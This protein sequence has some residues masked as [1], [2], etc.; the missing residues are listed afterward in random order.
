[1]SPGPWLSCGESRCEFRF[2]N[3]VRVAILTNVAHASEVEMYL[4][5]EDG[6]PYGDQVVWPLPAGLPMMR[7]LVQAQAAEGL[8]AAFACWKKEQPCS[9]L[10]RS[11]L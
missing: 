7:A 5:G 3:G 6:E 11:A 9:T 2:A 8:E 10:L 4:V 1:M